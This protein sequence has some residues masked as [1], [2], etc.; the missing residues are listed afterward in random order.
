MQDQES[1]YD[2]CRSALPQDS[3]IALVRLI[4]S[5]VDSDSETNGCPD[6]SSMHGASLEKSF[7]KSF[8]KS[9]ET[10]QTVV[11]ERGV[12]IMREA[13]LRWQE[14]KDACPRTTPGW[15]VQNWADIEA[16]GQTS[17]CKIQWAKLKK[18]E[19]ASEKVCMVACASCL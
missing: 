8:D 18:P 19:R 12:P 7:D 2:S 10:P 1:F 6:N 13:D 4:K 9:F 17:R 14:E 5:D 3:D 16:G 15:W 11:R